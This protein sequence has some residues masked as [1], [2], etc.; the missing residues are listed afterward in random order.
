MCKGIPFLT[1]YE[2]PQNISSI[3]PYI[4]KIP[5]D[6]SDIDIEQVVAFFEKIQQ[7]SKEDVL[8]NMRNFAW[9]YCDISVAM[10]TIVDYLNEGKI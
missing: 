4:L 6:E 2:L 7:E 10:Q 9:K 8:N 1:E 5:A 3:Y